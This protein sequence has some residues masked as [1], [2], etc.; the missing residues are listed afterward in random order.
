[1]FAKRYAELLLLLVLSA[2]PG[3]TPARAYAAL[4]TSFVAL[5]NLL[6]RPLVRCSSDSAHQA[7]N[8][9]AFLFVSSPP[10]F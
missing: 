6:L 1:M 8:V 9:L 5:T 3:L 2:T 10:F 4:A 7:L